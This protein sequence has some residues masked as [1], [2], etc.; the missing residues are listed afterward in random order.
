M[1]SD[2][3]FMDYVL[4]QARGAGGISGRRMFGEYALYCD[5]KVV[6]FVCDNRLF[7]KP[8]PAAVGLVDAPE[9]APPYPGAKLYLALDG[10]LDDGDLV[11][12]L[13]RVVADA[14]P[15]PKQKVKRPRKG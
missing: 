15:A 11:A 8:L 3:E 13:V 1:A 5:G 9:F 10:E 4:D 14:L 12:R 2:P 6:G 7:L